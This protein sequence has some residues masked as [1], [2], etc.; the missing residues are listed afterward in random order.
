MGSCQSKVVQKTGDEANT[1]A[2]S[3]YYTKEENIK[4]VSV[5]ISFTNKTLKS[6]CEFRKKIILFYSNMLSF[7]VSFRSNLLSIGSATQCL[8]QKQKKK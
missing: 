2:T 3:M 1:S 4:S 6:H 7:H 8:R 5:G